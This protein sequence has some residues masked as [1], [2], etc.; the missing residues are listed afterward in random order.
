MDGI[1]LESPG[2]VLAHVPDNA[3]R[4]IRALPT[5]ATTDSFLF[6]EGG[7]WPEP[8]RAFLE[9]AQVEVMPKPALGTL[10]PRHTYCSLPAAAAVLEG[11]ASLAEGLSHGEVCDHLHVFRGDRVL[12]SGYDAFDDEFWLA[13]DVPEQSVRTFSEAVGCTYRSGKGSAG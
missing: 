1:S 5:L 2:W 12:L 7:T 13:A 10:W 9:Q 6:L 8:L 3:S 11:L 4:F